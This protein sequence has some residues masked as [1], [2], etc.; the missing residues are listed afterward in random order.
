MIDFAKLVPLNIY[1][2]DSMKVIKSVIGDEVNLDI[3]Q[4]LR[5]KPIFKQPIKSLAIRHDPKIYFLI[6][7]ISLLQILSYLI[8]YCHINIKDIISINWIAVGVIISRTPAKK[9]FALL[10]FI[11]ADDSIFEIS[12]NSNQ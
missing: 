5:E 2:R 11:L 1:Q 10:S 6:D 9:S 3:L 12:W 8:R 7:G 4:L